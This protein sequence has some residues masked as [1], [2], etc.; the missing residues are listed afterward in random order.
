MKPARN[1]AAGRA[2]R[3]RDGFAKQYSGYLFALVGQCVA[4]NGTF[5]PGA[6]CR[7]FDA[8]TDLPVGLTTTSDANGV[9]VFYTATNCPYYCRFYLPGAPNFFGTTDILVPS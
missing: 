5:V 7:L 2:A 4:A 6:T 1:T 9:F 3:L 8:Y